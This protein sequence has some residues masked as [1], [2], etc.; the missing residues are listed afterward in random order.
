[1]LVLL[2]ALD[3]GYYAELDRAF[4]PVI[5][6]SSL[7]PAVGVLRDSVGAGPGVRRGR[8]RRAARRGRASALVAWAAV[9]VARLSATHRR[10]SAWAVGALALVWVASATLGS[11][12]RRR[13]RS[14]RGSTTSFAA[15]EVRNVAAAARDRQDFP[16]QL[17][18]T[19]PHSTTPTSD[20][21]TGLRG[22]D[23]I[24]AF[25]ESYGQTAVQGSTFAPGID[26]VLD[27]GHASRSTRPA[28]PRAARS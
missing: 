16:D 19:D 26:S 27:S 6:W 14:P 24:V 11:T 3:M 2:K 8:R 13:R 12:S 17:A 25:V 15:T 21:L 1:M 20:L 4:N 23:V 7:G 22:K 18:A 9:R 10:G 28:S 5:E